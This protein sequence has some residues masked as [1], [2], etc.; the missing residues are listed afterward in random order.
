MKNYVKFT[1]VLALVLALSGSGCDSE[2]ITISTNE[3]ATESTATQTQTEDT[4]T[5]TQESNTTTIKGKLIDSPVE[6]VN[7]VCADGTKG[8]TNEEGEFEC[9][10]LP[11]KFMV[12]NV[13]L[14]EIKK[15]PEDSVITPQ[16]LSGVDIDNLEDKTVTNIAI[17]L[18]SLDNDGDL[19]NTITIDDE[20]TP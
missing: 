9:K 2:S 6:G 18:Q 15:I 11:V 13:H 19:N 8:V 5:P 3:G 10:E 4:T 12:G 14:G 17:L 1:S 20:V 16:D 7:Y